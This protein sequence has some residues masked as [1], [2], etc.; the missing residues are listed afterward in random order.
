MRH[1]KFRAWDSEDQEMLYNRPDKLFEWQNDAPTLIIEQWTGLT[2]KI[3][4]DIYEG[5]LIDLN[6]EGVPVP[7]EV[8]YLDCRFYLSPLNITFGN[9]H[10]FVGCHE[11]EVIGTIHEGV[12]EIDENT[13]TVL[14]HQG[15]MAN[16]RRITRFKRIEKTNN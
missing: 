8:R 11:Y 16:S 3:G 10:D 7:A 2:D 6:F 5:D 9:C 13:G 12:K 4:V 15:F 14:N 1:F